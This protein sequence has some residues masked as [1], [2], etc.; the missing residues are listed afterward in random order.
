MQKIRQCIFCGRLSERSKL[1]LEANM[2]DSSRIGRDLSLSVSNNVLLGS[3]ILADFENVGSEFRLNT[4]QWFLN[5]NLH[6]TAD[7]W[8]QVSLNNNN[9]K[10]GS[11]SAASECTD[12]FILD[13]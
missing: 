8:Q 6:T 2:T 13:Y 10:T 5:Q 9:K 4:V 12:L 11:D 7:L 3:A 1:R